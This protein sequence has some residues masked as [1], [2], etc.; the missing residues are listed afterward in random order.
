MAAGV[1]KS[2]RV[3]YK[4]SSQLLSDG[5]TLKAFG[6]FPDVYRD[7]IFPISVYTSMTL[8]GNSSGG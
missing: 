6:N 3:M 2:G 1:H 7:N 8:G 5:I 4:T